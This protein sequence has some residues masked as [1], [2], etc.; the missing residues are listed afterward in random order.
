MEIDA[1]SNYSESR[2]DGV[3]LERKRELRLIPERGH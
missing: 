3:V 2:W 1:L